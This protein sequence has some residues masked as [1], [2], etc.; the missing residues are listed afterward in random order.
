MPGTPLIC[1]LKND[2]TVAGR[3]QLHM[4]AIS[5]III[6]KEFDIYSR[7]CPPLFV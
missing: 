7:V 5:I 3:R 4:V 1:R 6:V 2:Q